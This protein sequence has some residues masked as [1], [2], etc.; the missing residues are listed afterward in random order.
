MQ[1][2]RGLEKAVRQLNEQEIEFELSMGQLYYQKFVSMNDYI[3]VINLA[4]H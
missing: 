1:A 2:A 3:N 4:R